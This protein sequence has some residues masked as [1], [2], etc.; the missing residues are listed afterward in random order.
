V[1]RANPT[2]FATMFIAAN[3][4]IQSPTTND[5]VLSSA[6]PDQIAADEDEREQH[7]QDEIEWSEGD[8]VRTALVFY[9][10][11][12]GIATREECLAVEHRGSDRDTTR[13]QT[14]NLRDCL[15]RKAKEPFRGQIYANV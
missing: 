3:N 11:W 6:G 7:H 5:D 10:R 4:Q 15:Q 2:S 9:G 8:E 14:S 12:A 1:A 13:N